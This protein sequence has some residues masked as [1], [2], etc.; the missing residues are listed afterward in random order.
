MHA[1]S[2]SFQCLPTC[3]SVSELYSIC[4]NLWMTGSRKKTVVAYYVGSLRILN[5]IFKTLFWFRNAFHKCNRRENCDAIINVFFKKKIKKI[6]KH[7]LKLSRSD[8]AYCYFYFVIGLS[9][10]CFSG[11]LV[12]SVVTIKFS[13]AFY[14]EYSVMGLQP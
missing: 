11:N 5:R 10:I 1:V 9:P 6:S 3:L 2:I 4:L 7:H 8:S 14:S 12:W 13:V